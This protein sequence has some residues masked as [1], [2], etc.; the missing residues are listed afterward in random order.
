[1]HPSEKKK[2]LK[3]FVLDQQIYL[4]FSLNELTSE[5]PMLP[6]IRKHIQ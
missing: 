4:K 1:M 3:N 5:L 6:A 2:I